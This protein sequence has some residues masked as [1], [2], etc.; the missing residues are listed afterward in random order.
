M[1]NIDLTFHGSRTR[2]CNAKQWL[3]LTGNGLL[4]IY[5]VPKII[6]KIGPALVEIYTGQLTSSHK[7]KARAKLEHF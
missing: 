1:I 2:T 4:W 3:T 6:Q 5:L 7:G